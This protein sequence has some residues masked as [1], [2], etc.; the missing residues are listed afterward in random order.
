MRQLD[1]AEVMGAHP[2]TPGKIER[3][4]S[5]PEWGS[6]SRYLD[7]VGAGF[8]D[9]ARAAGEPP[10]QPSGVREASASAFSDDELRELYLGV[11]ALSRRVAE[12]ESLVREGGDEER[13]PGG[14]TPRGGRR[15]R[16]R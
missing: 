4:D 3:D 8:A 14:R 9:L 11:L 13:R 2:T 6:V 10:R 15:G 12:L 1:V 5:N 7:A 16:Q